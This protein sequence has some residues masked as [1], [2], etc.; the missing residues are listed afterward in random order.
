MEKE[1]RE[2]WREGRK[3]S[4]T[5]ERNRWPPMAV[6]PRVQMGGLFVHGNGVRYR[7]SSYCTGTAGPG[8]R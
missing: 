4:R 8:G 6:G 7:G 1:W 2:G 5:A 3:C